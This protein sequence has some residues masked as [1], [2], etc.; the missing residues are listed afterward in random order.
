MLLVMNPSLFYPVIDDPIL[1]D[2]MML[3]PFDTR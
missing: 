1:I 2:V 3:R